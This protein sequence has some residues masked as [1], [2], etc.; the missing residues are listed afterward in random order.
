[1]KTNGKNKIGAGTMWSWAV[2]VAMAAGAQ[3]ASISYVGGAGLAE[4]VAARQSAIGTAAAMS[5][6]RAPPASQ[7]LAAAWRLVPVAGL[8]CS[9]LAEDKISYADY[10]ESAPWVALVR[11]GDCPFVDKVRTL[12]TLGAAAVVVADDSS[13]LQDTR[14][15][16][17]IAP[18][19]QDQDIHIPSFFISAKS[20]HKLLREASIAASR[21]RAYCHTYESENRDRTG[22]SPNT[23]APAVARSLWARIYAFLFP[24]DLFEGHKMESDSSASHSSC[25]SASSSSSQQQPG[26]SQFLRIEITESTFQN[27]LYLISVFIAAPLLSSFMFQLIH[28]VYLFKKSIDNIIASRTH[29]Y[30]Y[31]YG[32]RD[33]LC[34]ICL[35]DYLDGDLLRILPCHHEYHVACVDRSIG[36]DETASDVDRDTCKDENGFLKETARER[37]FGISTDTDSVISKESYNVDNEFEATVPFI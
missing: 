7:R 1:M 9:V 17:M 3:A 2:V 20:Y 14:L 25:L 5:E 27:K 24:E 33:N 13:P 15:V 26:N 32:S 29:E 8:A 36:D 23:I 30:A 18:Y 34:A 22:N 10:S 28:F 37:I 6:H 35:D 4:R 11:R 31:E 21:H 12:Q 16:T 19:N